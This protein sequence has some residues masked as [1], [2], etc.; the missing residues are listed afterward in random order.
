MMI[1]TLVRSGVDTAAAS[2][3]A[4]IIASS[5]G[6]L[7][8]PA[9]ICNMVGRLHDQTRFQIEP[10]GKLIMIDARSRVSCIPRKH[11]SDSLHTNKL[12]PV[13]ITDV[14]YVDDEAIFITG[15]HNEE[16]VAHLSSRPC[17]VP[18]QRVP[19]RDL[20]VAVMTKL[21]SHLVRRTHINAECAQ[22][23][24]GGV[25]SLH[26]SLMVPPRASLF[27]CCR[28]SQSQLRRVKVEFIFTIDP[29]TVNPW[30]D[31]QHELLACARSLFT[32]C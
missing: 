18:K 25:V 22:C 7:H 24:L 29:C 2:H 13:P 21:P 23:V 11:S 8:Q 17:T 16:L 3:L 4:P 5:G 31:R 10:E 9:H 12:E 20:V 26:I 27:P 6:L 28:A 15:A 1:D 30:S 32:L 14:T 19:R